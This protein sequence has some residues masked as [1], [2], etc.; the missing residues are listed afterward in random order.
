MGRNTSASPPS[1]QADVDPGDGRDESA[2][3]RLDRNWNSLLQELRVLQTGTQLLTG[4]LL[5]IVFQPT[6]TKLESWQV[7]LYLA[8]VSLS[9]FSTLLVLMP[10]A[11]HRTVFRQHGMHLLV[12]WGDRMVRLGLLAT[13]LAIVGVIALV[14]SAAVGVLGAVIG[15]IG[16]VVAIAVLWLALPAGLRR[17]LPDPHD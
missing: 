13:G 14:F 6:F 12:Q 3:E 9:T 7:G 15:S 1:D 5:T 8:V 4:F 11:L 2:A 17:K 10:V 16:A